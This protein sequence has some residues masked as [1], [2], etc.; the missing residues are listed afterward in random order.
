[1][2]TIVSMGVAAAL[3]LGSG[4]AGA[5]P[6][7]KQIFGAQCASCHAIN[8]PAA[9]KDLDRIWKRKGPDLYHAGDKFRPEWLAGWLQ[10]PTRVRPGGVFYY[11]HV[12][13]GK[14]GDRL[15]DAALPTHPALAAADAAAVA[16]YLAGLHAPSGYIEKAP[17]GKPSR[18]DAKMGKLFF[19]KL[20]GCA[21]CHTGGSKGGESGPELG[22]AGA[23]LRPDYV[24]SY[25][26]NP[27]KFDP[28]V[29][30]P[31]L[32][33]SEQDL[34]RLTAYVLSLSGKED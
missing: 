13:A 8:A 32:E 9:G 18:M 34:K 11:R 15:D 25:I 14:D 4:V 10:K 27:Q 16:D 28:G 29:W 22:D 30:M 2:R 12:K 3:S 17:A 1:M 7:G 23:R 33:L 26:K 20:R 21:A 19:A 24:Y 6:D 5:A 31:T